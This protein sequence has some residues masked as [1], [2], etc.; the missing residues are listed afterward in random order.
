LEGTIRGLRLA[1]F[2]NQVAVQNGTVVVDSHE[3]ERRN[4]H[5]SVLE[6]NGVDSVLVTDPG[7]PWVRYAPKGELLALD[8]IFPDGIEIPEVLFGKNVVH[9]PT[10]Q[11]HV[12]T[13]ITVR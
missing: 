13:T 5:S 1:G 11:T 3:G 2:R 10:V 9:L 4:K 7:V 8:R 12:F 6:R